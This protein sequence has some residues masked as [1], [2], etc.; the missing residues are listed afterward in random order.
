MGVAY[1]LMVWSLLYKEN[2]FFRF[3]ENCFVG[4]ACGY[5]LTKAIDSLNSSGI[6]PIITKARYDLIIP[7]IL[8]I[9]ILAKFKRNI[10]F[11]SQWGVNIMVGIATGLA[12][13]GVL[14]AQVI[15]QITATFI[16]LSMM[17]NPLAYFNNI[18]VLIS[19]ISTIFYFIFTR[20]PSGHLKYIS[21]I[22]RYAIMLALG[23]VF[24]SNVLTRMV[25]LAERVAFFL[26]VLGI[27]K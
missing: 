2:R 1:L 19:V 26:R 23:P 5:T 4:A 3:A 24:A 9:L 10:A 27:I 14:Q 20:E 18:F 22:G 8:G 7:M 17:P 21:K 6:S 11:V 25:L 13:R 15:V 16:S 12:I